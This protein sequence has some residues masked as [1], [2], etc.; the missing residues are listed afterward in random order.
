M[1]PVKKQT[2]SLDSPN[3]RRTI[4]A[5]SKQDQ[6]K[7]HIAKVFSRLA[8][9]YRK[10]KRGGMWIARRH[11]QGAKYSFEPLGIADDV[12][13]ADGI[14]VLSFD[15]AKVKAAEWFKRKGEEDS[16]EI[17]VGSYTVNDAMDDYL[18]DRAREKW[19][20]RPEEIDTHPKAMRTRTII[21]AHIRPA[22]GDI[23]GSKLRHNK[24]KAWRN[25]IADAAPRVRSR[26]GK[27]QAFRAFDPNDPDA[28][29]KRQA[30]AN[31][32]LTVLKAGLNLAKAEKRI[33]T[34]A[35]WV[36]IKPFRE[37][38]VPKIRFLKVDSEKEIDEV[39]PLV[40][41]CASD[42]Q[43][44]VKGALMT[45]ARYEES[46]SLVVE[47]FNANNSNV[48]IAKSKNGESRYVDLNDEGVALFQQLT[49]GRKPHDRIFL[50]ANGKPWKQSEQ[51]RPMNAACE[52]ANVEGV[53]FHI[54]RHTYA[55][56]AAMNGMP[57]EVLAKQLGH[58]DTRITIRHYAHLCP[59]FKQRSVK[60]NAP[61]FGFG[62]TLDAP[63]P[64]QP[65]DHAPMPTKSRKGRILTM[66]RTERAG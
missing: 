10:G 38:D 36:D 17:I 53:T 7:L 60:A 47:D 32:V 31:R 23:E 56:H 52:A 14:Q 26:V 42:F 35:A 15:Q 61:K 63:V 13:D 39:T 41:A 11:E 6:K 2:I 51:F 44:L 48:Y 4:P 30:T 54:L 40:A 1:P 21:D 19:K 9:G 27:E 64:T 25:A 66:A 62:A 46:T 18:K 43:K 22:L 20:I 34:D 28:I 12:A 24:V 5:K 58:K 8:L 55:S 29:R 59:N 57:I 65:A 33:A 3:S 16:G 37:V 49:E 45:G 50:K